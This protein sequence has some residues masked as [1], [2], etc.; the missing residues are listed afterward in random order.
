MSA[1]A[2]SEVTQQE[3]NDLGTEGDGSIAPFLRIRVIGQFSYNAFTAS[4][5][6][7]ACCC[8][9]LRRLEGWGVR[10]VCT[11]CCGLVC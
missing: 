2:R 4:G 9:C 6:S 10:P 5:G 3:G 7:T 11:P 8:L 1:V